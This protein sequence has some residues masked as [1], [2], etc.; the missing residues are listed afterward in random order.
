MSLFK[1][2]TFENS[3]RP[4]LEFRPRDLIVAA[5]A[6]FVCTASSSLQ[7]SEKTPQEVLC[8]V[9]DNFWDGAN[10][11]MASVEAEGTFDDSAPRESMRQL[12]VLNERILQLI[13]IHQMQAH[14]CQTPKT[15]SSGIGYMIDAARCE[16]ERSK[17]NVGA[18]ECDQA[19]W[20]SIL[21]DLEHFR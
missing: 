14:G 6:A 8:D 9:Y 12:K 5:L 7:A 18:P 10:K 3:S 19:N 4:I 13:V 1:S 17:G 15:I 2:W 11:T 21:G 16:T 20:K